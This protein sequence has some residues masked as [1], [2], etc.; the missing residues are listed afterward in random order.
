MK[1]YLEP[2]EVELMG[3]VAACFR[4]RLLIRLL[5][6]LGIIILAVALAWHFERIKIK[7]E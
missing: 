1:T 7:R 2:N 6:R 3:K 5:F 4:D